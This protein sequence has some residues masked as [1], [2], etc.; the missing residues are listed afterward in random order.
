MA[1]AP[2]PRR[3]TTWYNRIR[4]ITQ[5]S[6][7]LII[8]DLTHPMISS[9]F[10][11]TGTCVRLI[12]QLRATN[13]TAVPDLVSLAVGVAVVTQDAVA[14]GFIAMPNPL[15]DVE[16]DWYL[17]WYGNLGV[18]DH[19]VLFLDRDIRSARRLRGGY[20]LVLITETEVTELST[21]IS[22]M[23]RTLWMLP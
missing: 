23:A 19:T 10:E 3:R 16:Q 2:T 6:V 4:K 13:I 5:P 7:G 22:V 14:A 8:T 11:S 20:R 18:S 9:G 12:I 21:E 1:R 17:W 15:T